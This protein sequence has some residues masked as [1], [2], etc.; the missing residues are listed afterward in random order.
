LRKIPQKQNGKL[1]SA[2]V[3]VIIAKTR[4]PEGKFCGRIKP[5]ID[6]AIQ[7]STA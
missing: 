7:F 4:I 5:P 2:L 6:S 1:Q 3:G